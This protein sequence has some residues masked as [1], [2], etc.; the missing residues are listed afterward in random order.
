MLLS[1]SS[2][3][4]FREYRVEPAESDGVAAAAV[5]AARALRSTGVGCTAFAVHLAHDRRRVVTVEAWA[6]E[7]AAREHGR[8]G[9]LAD[10]RPTSAVYRHTATAGVAPTPVTDGSAGVIVIDCFRVWR[11]LVRPVSAFNARNGRSFDAAPGCVSTTVLRSTRTGRIATYARWRTTADFLA[12]FTA[13]QGTAVS[14]TDEINDAAAAMTR[15]LLRTDYH[16]YELL[17][18]DEGS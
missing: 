16:T 11:P 1:R 13:T 8:R 6:D 2:P 12:A 7:R 3:Q 18:A 15:G 9:D 4:V 10:R 5:T 17:D 14:S